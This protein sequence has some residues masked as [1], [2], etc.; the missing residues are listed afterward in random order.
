M[1]QPEGFIILG[2]ENLVSKLKKSLYGL[3]QSLRQ[4]YK[5]FD[6]FMFSHGFKWSDYDSYV[7]LKI[8]NGSSIYLLLYVDDMLIAAK[9]KLEIAKL[10]EQLRQRT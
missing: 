6:S 3:K 4:W 8:V 5:R 10:K 9:E 2:K 1:N 7:Y